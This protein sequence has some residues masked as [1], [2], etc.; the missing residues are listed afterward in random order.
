M[1]PAR[2]LALVALALTICSG[3]VGDAAAGRG[4]TPVRVALVVDPEAGVEGVTGLEI[5]GL[6]RAS[7]DFG[8]ETRVVTHTI[9]TTY[10]STFRSLAREGYDLVVAASVLQARGALAAAASS[11][12]T[13]F[14]LMDVRAADAGERTPANV[15]NLSFR[16]EEIGYV[17]GYLAGL[18]ER[19]RPGRDVVA[20]IG[21]EPVPPVV[22]FMAG[23]RAGARRA[24]PRVR[25]LYAYSGTFFV[26]ESC[27]RAAIAL[28]AKGAGVLLPVAGRCGL[29][30]LATAKDRG[31][32]AIGADVDQ[33]SLG[34]HILTSALKRFDV[35]VYRAVGLLARRR[36][37]T[38]RDVTLGVREGALDLG[39]I[40]PRVRPSL[41][42][43]TRATMREI[44]SGRIAGIP[45][46]LGD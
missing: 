40:S 18:V 23:Y 4:A 8:V 44:A 41:V 6:Q 36:L 26:P 35:A 39:R 29:G 13:R 3:V 27:E 38:G 34:P 10:A 46:S 9:R 22:R 17:V 42:R 37:A 14:A 30:A 43:R 16:E 7:R 24:N 15:V 2:R 1:P 12:D 19:A 33:S 25:H 31:L 11:P 28:A 32:F 45:T 5:V 21:G 20:S